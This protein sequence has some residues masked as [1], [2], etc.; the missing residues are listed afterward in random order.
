MTTSTIL[1]NIDLELL[2]PQE[3]ATATHLL[4]CTKHWDERF[5]FNVCEHFR[6]S[7]PYLRHLRQEAKSKKEALFFEPRLLEEAETLLT[8][9]GF[10]KFHETIGPRVESQHF[11]LR[12]F[13]TESHQWWAHPAGVLVNL[14]SC[15]Q[16]DG[17][18]RYNNIS[19]H[20]QI[21]GDGAGALLFGIESDIGIQWRK[22]LSSRRE[23]DLPRVD[24]MSQ[25]LHIIDRL[26]Q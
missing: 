2:S 26:S 3:Q 13:G 24:P 16:Q 5:L 17:H 14:D 15:G 11:E 23:F 22:I 12:D 19:V 20:A 25:Q 4:A 8:K 6:Q 1:P 9:A 21:D 18:F 7:N 10:V